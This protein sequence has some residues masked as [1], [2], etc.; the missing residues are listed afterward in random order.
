MASS[1][2]AR[3]WFSANS[4]TSRSDSGGT[5]AANLASIVT[6]SSA[7]SKPL[8]HGPEVADIAEEEVV[9]IVA[10]AGPH[11]GMACDQDEFGVDQ[12]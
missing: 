9:G 11:D 3:S 6:T 5:P 7:A 2:G 8:A 12:L 4:R 1:G 10:R